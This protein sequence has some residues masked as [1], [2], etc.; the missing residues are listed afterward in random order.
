MADEKI[1]VVEQVAQTAYEMARELW[2]LK[3][4]RPPT[5]DDEDFLKLVSTSARALKGDFSVYS[6][7]DAL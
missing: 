1:R 5:M 3:H 7:R 6:W 4:D 2:L